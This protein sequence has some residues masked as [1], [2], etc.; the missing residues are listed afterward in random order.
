MK[1]KRIRLALILIATIITPFTLLAGT[2]DNAPFIITLPSADWKLSDSTSQKINQDIL[3]V[4]T[5]VNNRSDLESHVCT[6]R[7]QPVPF[8][9][10]LPS[11]LDKLCADVNRDM[12]VKSAYKKISETD[13][14]FVGIKAKALA[15]EWTQDGGAYYEQ[16][17]VF[18]VGNTGW[19]ITFSGPAAQKEA[20]KQMIT[21]YRPKKADRGDISIVE[22]ALF[23]HWVS[24][25]GKDHYYF[26]EKAVEG[27]RKSK[28]SK[29]MN[30]GRA[31]NIDEPCNTVGAHLSKVSL[32]STDP[33][34]QI[35]GRY[36]MFTPREVARIQSFPDSFVL[37]SSK[38]TNY[39]ALGNAVA[40]VVMWHVVQ[41][42]VEALDNH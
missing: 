25:S 9:P 29:S 40:P 17:V 19:I 33:V 22:K 32:N 14:T 39:K 42:I 35:D 36:R 34:M 24:E 2:L 3:L 26:S 10:F 8:N 5:F 15:Y 41:K 11:T 12:L 7:C 37:P 18:I 23:G 1:H 27:M 30:K 38:S 13:T 28:N 20:L 4:A 31:Q 6:T 21:F 16:G